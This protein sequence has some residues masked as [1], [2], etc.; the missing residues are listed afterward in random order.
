[1]NRDHVNLATRRQT[2][3]LQVRNEQVMNKLRDIDSVYVERNQGAG[4]QVR[5]IGGS[6]QADEFAYFGVGGG[7]TRVGI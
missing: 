6:I 1:M 5:N 4:Q 2:N 3:R 7:G